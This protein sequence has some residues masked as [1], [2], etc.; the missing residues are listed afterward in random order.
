MGWGSRPSASRGALP[1]RPPPLLLL[2]LLLLPPPPTQALAPRISLPLG[3]RWGD[4]AGAR[5]GVGGRGGG[6]EVPV[7]RLP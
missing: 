5:A 3:E 2:L 7:R 1:P 4:P 6:W